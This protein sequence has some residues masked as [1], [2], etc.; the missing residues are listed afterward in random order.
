MKYLYLTL[1]PVF[2]ITGSLLI[3]LTDLRFTG[4]SFIILWVAMFMCIPMA[5]NEFDD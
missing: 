1:I 5:L 3:D 4:M 2:F